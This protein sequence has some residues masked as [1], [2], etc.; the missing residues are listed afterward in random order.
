MQFL[1]IKYD[2]NRRFLVDDL[3][4]DEEVSLFLVCYHQ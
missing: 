4:P 3:Y 1:T 2:V